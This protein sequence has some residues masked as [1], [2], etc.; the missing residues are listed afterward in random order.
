MQTCSVVVFDT[1]IG[2][3]VFALDS[4]G[5]IGFMNWFI[6]KQFAMDVIQGIVL[7]SEDTRVGSV[8]YSTVSGVAF[9]ITAKQTKAQVVDAVWETGYTAGAT[10]TADAIEQARHMLLANT[11][12]GI[13]QFIVLITDGASNVDKTRTIVE[14]QLARNRDI[15]MFVVGKCYDHWPIYSKYRYMAMTIQITLN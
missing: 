2:D 15:F 8:V 10:N 14:A 9:P 13:A 1:C 3:F 6:L 7:D 5:S 12:A 11:R 4:S